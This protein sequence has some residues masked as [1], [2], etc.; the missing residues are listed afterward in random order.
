M[1][2]KNILI[3]SATSKNNLELAE[4]IESIIDTSIVDSEVLN[5]DKHCLPIFTEIFFHKN[6]NNYLTEAKFITDKFVNADGII[7]CAP[8]YNGSIPPIVSNTIA[9]ISMSTEYWRDGFNNKVG[10]LCSHSG[11]QARKFITSMKLQL[12]HLGMIIVPRNI[13]LNSSKQFNIDSSKK[14]LKQFIKLL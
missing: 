2:K 13:V 8:E 3:I 1:I 14:I 5:L 7:V 6:K 12:E 11:G 10:L 4:K 9:W